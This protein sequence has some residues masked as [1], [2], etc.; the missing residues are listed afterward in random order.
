MITFT[1]ADPG[2]AKAI[3]EMAPLA[4]SGLCTLKL[5]EVK[6]TA[7]K[8]GGATTQAVEATPDSMESE[9]RTR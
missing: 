1:A 4:K 5:R 8:L 9:P 6:V 3:A 7:A 2:I